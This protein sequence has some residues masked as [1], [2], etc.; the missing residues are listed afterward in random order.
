MKLL[1]LLSSGIDS[2]VAAYLM[3]QKKHEVRCI[4]FRAGAVK[5]V[6]ELAKSKT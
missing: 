5:Q 6:K 4:H 1:C 2:P 3:K